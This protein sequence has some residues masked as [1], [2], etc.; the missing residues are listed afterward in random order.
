M[1]LL[2]C[3]NGLSQLCELLVACTSA[4][5]IIEKTKMRHTTLAGQQL[6]SHVPSSQVLLIVAKSIVA[7]FQKVGSICLSVF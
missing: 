4:H 7:G 2:L 3:E 1:S 5:D 6:S